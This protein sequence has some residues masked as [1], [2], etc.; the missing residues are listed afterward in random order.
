MVEQ[1]QPASEALQEIAPEPP[2]KRK[3]RSD[4]GKRRGRRK[5][6]EQQIGGTL[7]MLNLAFMF[8][9]EEFRGDALD[10]VEIS[11][12]AKALNDAAKEN[13]QLY[14]WLNAALGGTGSALVSLAVVGVAIAG[15]R[16]ARHNIIVAEE[17]DARLGA[18]I[19]MNAGE[20]P[21]NTVDFSQLFEAA[22]N[23]ATANAEQATEKLNGNGA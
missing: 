10:D 9:P 23:E 20:M 5:N 8:A 6:L 13:D 22:A 16:M 17:W 15:R 7:T 12:L 1:V 2:K 3:E 18:F 14:D 19:A 4:K 11:A 21:E